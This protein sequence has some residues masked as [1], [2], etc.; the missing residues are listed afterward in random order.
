[1]KTFLVVNPRSAGGQTGKHWAELSAQVGRAIGEFGHGFTEG[2]MDAAR[3]ARKAVQDGYECVVAVGGDGT[4][5]EVVNGFFLDGRAINP[6]AALGVIPRG[7]GGDF[8][9]AFGWDLELDS[10]LARLS[11]GQTEPFDV[12]LIEYVNHEGKPEQRYFANI[13]SFGVSAVVAHEVNKSSKA[14]GGNLSFVW[15]TVKGLIKYSAPMVRFRADAGT[16]EPV[17]VTAVAVANGRYF[18][19]G[20]CV[21]PGAL[22]HDGLFNVTVW[23]GYGLN[24]FI[25]KSKGVYSGEHVTWKG[26]RQLQCRSFEAESEDGQEVLI[27]VDG[28]VPG[29]LPAK[30]TILPGAIRLKV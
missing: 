13:A 7:T 22:T 29:R 1:M 28:E 2:A 25:F 26:T 30:M 12:G 19:S 15:G 20:M 9:R 24:D 14:L 10:A 3:I 5:N 27:E 18:G 23:S 8:R 17:S 11:T 4:I 6:Q 21:A 16:Q